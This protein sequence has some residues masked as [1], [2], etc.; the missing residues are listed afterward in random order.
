MINCFC[1]FFFKKQEFNNNN[2]NN[3]NSISNL[4]IIPEYLQAQIEPLR[5]RII[6]I[7]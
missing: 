6:V 3:N 4:R 1:C 2:N 5:A 7:T